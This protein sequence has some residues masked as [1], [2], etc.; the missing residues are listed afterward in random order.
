[1]AEKRIPKDADGWVIP[2]NEPP[3]NLVRVWEIT[4]HHDKSFDYAVIRDYNSALDYANGRLN[5]LTEDADEGDEI[6]VKMVLRSMTLR[7]YEELTAN[8]D[9]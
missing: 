8:L 1:M 9:D 5:N 3:D 2:A 6:K 7:E 4:P